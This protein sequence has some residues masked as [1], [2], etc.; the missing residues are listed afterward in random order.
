MDLVCSGLDRVILLVGEV[1][2]AVGDP[3]D[4]HLSHL[5]NI[6]YFD[7]IMTS[8]DRLAATI[9]DI[10]D[11]HYFLSRLEEIVAKVSTSSSAIRGIDDQCYTAE[12]DL[13]DQLT[14]AFATLCQTKTRTIMNN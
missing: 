1:L 8:S 3:V 13:V 6:K 11:N 12:D 4:A 5:D 9:D 10:L 7:N 14:D 2:V